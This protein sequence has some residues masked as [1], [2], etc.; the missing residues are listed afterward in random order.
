MQLLLIIAVVAVLAVA[1]SAPQ[2]PLADGLFYSAL[3]F[4]CMTAAPLFAVAISRL[5]VAGLDADRTER[6]RRLRR[7]GHLRAM[8]AIV[9]SVST[10]AVVYFFGWTQLV[11]CNWQ[12]AGTFLADELLILLPVVAPMMLSWAAFYEVDLAVAASMPSGERTPSTRM[13]YVMLHARQ[14][15][16]LLLVPVLLLLALQDAVLSFAPRVDGQDYEVVV[17]LAALLVLL[18]FFPVLVRRVWHTTPLPMSS[19]RDRL[20]AVYRGHRAPV[21]EILVWQTGDRILNAAVAGFF[22]RCL[23]NIFGSLRPLPFQLGGF[24]RRLTGRLFLHWVPIFKSAGGVLD[25]VQAQTFR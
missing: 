13:S 17:Y 9:W 24:R 22:G 15:L 2:Q 20:V 4:A 19:L 23:T 16:G 1:D 3:A 10:L 18:V 7:F 25:C 14:Y 11:R 6:K 5:T 12:L 21:R 8:H